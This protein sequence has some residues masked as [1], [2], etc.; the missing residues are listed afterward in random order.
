VCSLVCLVVCLVVWQQVQPLRADPL[1]PH[2]PLA[3]PFP[4]ATQVPLTPRAP[5]CPQPPPRRPH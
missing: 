1:P 2:Q 3:H 4:P 5:F